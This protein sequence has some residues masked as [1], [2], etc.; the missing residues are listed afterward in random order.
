MSDGAK[1]A[2]VHAPSPGPPSGPREKWSPGKDPDPAASL[3]RGR[4]PHL[5]GH[6][7]VMISGPISVVGNQVDSQGT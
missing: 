3:R 6:Y 7:L 4:F 1:C 5:A 2:T